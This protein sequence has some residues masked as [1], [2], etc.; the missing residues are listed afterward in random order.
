MTY[1]SVAWTAPGM[2]E[3]STMSEAQY[4]IDPVGPTEI[5]AR[6]N[7][8]INTIHAWNYDKV[9]PPARWRVGPGPVWDWS[10]IEAWAIATGRMTTLTSAPRPRCREM[11]DLVGVSEIAKRL[12]ITKRAVHRRVQRGQMPPPRWHVSARGVWLWEDLKGLPTNRNRRHTS[13]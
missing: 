8:P 13:R 9:L 7:V 3:A 1:A 11:P 10:D 6:L 5:A 12:D 4:E 2:S